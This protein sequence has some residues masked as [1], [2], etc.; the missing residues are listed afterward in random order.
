MS[1]ENLVKISRGVLQVLLGILT[2]SIT[3]YFFWRGFETLRPPIQWHLL[4]RKEFKK[5]SECNVRWMND[6]LKSLQ[7]QE[8]KFGA[9]FLTEAESLE[10]RCK[11]KPNRYIWEK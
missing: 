5:W 2:F 4:T 11:T 7:A 6:I 10:K 8:K 3:L 1:N 9:N